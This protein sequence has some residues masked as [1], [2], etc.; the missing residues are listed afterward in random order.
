MKSGPYTGERIDHEAWERMLDEYY[1]LRGWDKETGLQ[2]RQSLE[3]L[4]LKPIADRLEEAG[5]LP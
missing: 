4:G 5:C 3:A 2:T 1:N